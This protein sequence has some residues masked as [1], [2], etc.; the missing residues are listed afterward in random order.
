VQ[1]WPFAYFSPQALPAVIALY[2][3]IRASATGP[4]ATIA[5]ANRAINGPE[6]WIRCPPESVYYTLKFL[7]MVP[8]ALARMANEENHG[9]PDYN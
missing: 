6:S 1:K 5:I 8:A 7:Q 9:C 4:V 3:G 2:K